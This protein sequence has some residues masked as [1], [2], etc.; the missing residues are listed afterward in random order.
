MLFRNP[1]NSAPTFPN[2]P[3]WNASSDND[4]DMSSSSMTSGAI[5]APKVNNHQKTSERM[6]ED[7]SKFSLPASINFIYDRSCFFTEL[8]D[9]AAISA[10]LYANQNHPELKTEYPLWNDRQKQIMKKWRALS[11]DQKKP[12][13]SLAR[14]NRSAQQA[15]LRVKK[16][17]QVRIIVSF[18]IS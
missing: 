9:K 11:S 6:Q 2:Q 3:Q 4:F 14:D 15:E 12:Y 10:V 5:P 7:E 17:Q 18:T 8:G 13:L 16:A 1:F